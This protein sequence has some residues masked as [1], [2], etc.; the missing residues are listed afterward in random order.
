MRRHAHLHVP[1]DDLRGSVEPR[2]G[3]L[4]DGRAAARNAHRP[5]RL[6]RLEVGH[7]SRCGRCA[8]TALPVVIPFR[9]AAE[10]SFWLH[11]MPINSEHMPAGAAGAPAALR[12]PANLRP[13]CCCVRP[14]ILPLCS[15]VQV[16]NMVAMMKRSLPIPDSWPQPLQVA[17]Q[18]PAKAPSQAA[19][20]P[21]PCWPSTPA[22]LPSALHASPP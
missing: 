5:A 11:A 9:H 20:L 12:L 10:L 17:P 2:G 15:V 21:H 22:A 13:L 1:R 4:L 3:H 19:L 16:V 8:H 14:S 7:D 6:A 18:P